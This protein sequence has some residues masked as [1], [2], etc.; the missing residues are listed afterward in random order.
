VLV[1]GS[2]V[3]RR[4]DAYG[5]QS[6]QISLKLKLELSTVVSRLAWMLEP[7]SRLVEKEEAFF[8]TLPSL[9]PWFPISNFS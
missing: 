5:N 7:S 9:P 6:F 4:A 3:H 2:Y 1:Q 8:T